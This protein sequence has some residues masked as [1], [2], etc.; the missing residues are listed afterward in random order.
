MCGVILDDMGRVLLCQRPLEKSQGGLW[1]FPGGKVDSGET[2]ESALMRELTEELGCKVIV[3]ERL[4]EVEHNYG[5][6]SVSLVP[7]ICRLAKDSPAPQA[8]EHIE[9]KW[10]KLNELLSNKL[11]PADV[12][13]V[14]EL[15]LLTSI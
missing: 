1:E 10:L 13:I 15:Q 3:G 9:I 6:F 11:V 12:A 5:D 14:N 2:C 7:F 8:L 4:S